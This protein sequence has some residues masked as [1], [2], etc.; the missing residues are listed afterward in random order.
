MHCEDNQITNLDVS[1]NT[2]LTFLLCNKNIITGLNLKNNITLGSLSCRENLITDL[3]LGN[4][5]M[6]HR[7]ECSINDLSSTALNNLF[8][9]LHGDKIKGTEKGIYVDRNPG[10]YLCDISIAE[11]K[12]WSVTYKFP[13]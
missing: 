11:T 2:A 12:G 1:K 3:D 8:K 5:V 6:L 4:N 7:V 10:S 13:P 9:T